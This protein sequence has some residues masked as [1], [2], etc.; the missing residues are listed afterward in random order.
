[1][2]YYNIPTVN[3]RVTIMAYELRTD[4]GILLMRFKGMAVDNI[5]EACEGMGHWRSYRSKDMKHPVDAF[6]VDT[7]FKFGKANHMGE[8][9]IH[10]WEGY[11]LIPTRN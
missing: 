4:N 5:L 1:M 7:P 2:L 3:K 10:V 6:E 11:L 8:M 9:S